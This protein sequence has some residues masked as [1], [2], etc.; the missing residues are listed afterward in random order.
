MARRS[1]NNALGHNGGPPLEGKNHVPEWGRG[2]ISTY[3]SW[4][5]AHRAAWRRVP[6]D[7]ILR[8]QERAERAG[9]TYEEYTLEILERGVYLQPE[10]DERI[11]AIHAKRRKKRRKSL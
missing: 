4:R 11:A 5:S 9:V 6:F 10:D 3:F 7:T 1:K 2:G 8:R